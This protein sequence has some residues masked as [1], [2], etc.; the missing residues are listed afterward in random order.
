MYSDVIVPLSVCVC[1]VRAEDKLDNAHN[2][3]IP[4]AAWDTARNR[5]MIIES[6]DTYV[7]VA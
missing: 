6:I 7:G 5:C 4:F 3:K 1:C 2:W